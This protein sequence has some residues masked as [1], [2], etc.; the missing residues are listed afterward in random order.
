MNMNLFCEYAKRKFYP[1][2]VNKYYKY[3]YKFERLNY[4]GKIMALKVVAS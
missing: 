3:V 2:H 1:V 4:S